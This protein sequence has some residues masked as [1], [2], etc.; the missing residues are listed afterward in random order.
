MLRALE[1][2]SNPLRTIHDDAFATNPLSQ[3]WL[4]D[5]GLNQLPIA[6]QTESTLE[7]L[8]VNTNELTQLNGK[9]FVNLTLLSILQIRSN[10]IVTIDENAFVNCQQ[11]N[12]LDLSF[13]ST[14]TLPLTV[15]D[16]LTQLERF[17]W[18]GAA[19]QS[20]IRLQDRHFEKLTRL[21]ALDLNL[22]R[23]SAPFVKSWDMEFAER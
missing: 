22:L 14:T 19:L 5:C 1:L 20:S 17:R 6:V 2:T 23:G 18:A 15:F 4:E 12:E 10:P 7:R 21:Q 13:I 8:D 11:L 16:S 9:D 3:L